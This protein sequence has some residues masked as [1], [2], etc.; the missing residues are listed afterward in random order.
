V[1]GA[2]GLTNAG[3]ILLRRPVDLTAVPYLENEDRQG[4]IFHLVDDSIV[5]DA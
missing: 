4:V 2:L 5:P 1:L 3:P